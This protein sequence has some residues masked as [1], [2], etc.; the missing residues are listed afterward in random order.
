MAMAT[1]PLCIV[2]QQVKRKITQKAWALFI[3]FIESSNSMYSSNRNISFSLFT[4]IALGL[5]T[6]LCE[7]TEYGTT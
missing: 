6:E 1:L 4:V 2:K 7:Q 5:A 3:I